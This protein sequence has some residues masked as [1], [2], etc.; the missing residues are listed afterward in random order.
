MYAEF[1]NGIHALFGHPFRVLRPFL[2]NHYKHMRCSGTG[3]F[4]TSALQSLLYG[5]LCQ[6][7]PKDR[8]GFF[9]I[10]R[11]AWWECPQNSTPENTENC[12]GDCED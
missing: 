6:G 3:L 11:F 12:H 2:R 5:V 4:E 7:V 1:K 10:R 9:I 8:F